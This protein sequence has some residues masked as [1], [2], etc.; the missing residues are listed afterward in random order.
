MYVVSIIS[1]YIIQHK[2]RAKIGKSSFFRESGR[3]A[4]S[5]R[6]QVPETACQISDFLK[7]MLI[8]NNLRFLRWLLVYFKILLKR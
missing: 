8:Y 7:T 4:N 2:L 3:L 1:F 5:V 6:Q